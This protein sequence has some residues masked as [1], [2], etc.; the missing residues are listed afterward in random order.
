MMQITDLEGREGFKL[1][2]YLVHPP[3]QWG[4]LLAIR[5]GPW[6]LG[7][8]AVTLILAGGWRVGDGLFWVHSMRS[9]GGSLVSREA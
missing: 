1:E 5:T 7:R 9:S 2:V 4:T 3:A 6:E 8:H